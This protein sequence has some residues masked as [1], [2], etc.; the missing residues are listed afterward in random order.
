MKKSKRMFH[1]VKD[2]LCYKPILY[3]KRNAIKYSLGIMLFCCTLAVVSCSSLYPSWI[4]EPGYTPTDVPTAV[5]TNGKNIYK[6]FNL[7][8]VYTPD[9]VEG[10]NYCYDKTGG[11]IVL[12]N[13]INAVNP[14]YDQLVNFLQRDTTDQFTYELTQKVNPFYR[15]SAESHVDI[16]TIQ[17]IID[18]LSQPSN[19]KVCADFAERLHNNAELSGIRCGFVVISGLKHAIN[20]FQTSDKGLIY[21]DDT[22]DSTPVAA[23]K[24]NNSNYFGEAKNWD[25]VAYIQEGRPYGLISL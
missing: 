19:P 1:L 24:S 3:I 18:G 6:N 22:G 23:I 13:N 8:L 21:I 7:G 15:G 12:I 16:N 11:F 2:E 4:N 14:S 17:K 5:H 10:G 9:Y 20:M 25:K